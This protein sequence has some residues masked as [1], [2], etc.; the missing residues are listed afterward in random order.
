[1]NN[2]AD[3][4]ANNFSITAPDTFVGAGSV[5]ILYSEID[6]LISAFS[7]EASTTIGNYTFGK[8]IFDVPI[9]VDNGESFLVS[10]TGAGGISGGA[11][12]IEISGWYIDSVDY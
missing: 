9:Q 4:G 10:Y 11:M 8:I 2:S 5:T 1:M 7:P 3:L 12:R 6:K